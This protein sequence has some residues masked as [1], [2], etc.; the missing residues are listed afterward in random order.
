MP[1]ALLRP[2]IR[3]F[4]GARILSK[5]SDNEENNKNSLFG[6]RTLAVGISA[7]DTA[8]IFR[9]RNDFLALV[10]FVEG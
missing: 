8:N 7:D 3:V 9:S 4:L 2:K 1:L 5:E 6:Y 10:T